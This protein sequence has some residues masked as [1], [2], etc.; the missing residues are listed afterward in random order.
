[1][2]AMTICEFD[3]ATHGVL[4]H[5]KKEEKINALKEIICEASKHVADFV[6]LLCQ[7]DPELIQIESAL[8]EFTDNHADELTTSKGRTRLKKLLQKAEKRY[9]KIAQW[10]L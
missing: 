5:T 7:E 9:E 1:M 4:A 10:W 6:G 3:R 2:A 8:N